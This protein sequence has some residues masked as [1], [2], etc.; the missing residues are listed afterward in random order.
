MGDKDVY[1]AIT[2]SHTL[3]TGALMPLELG[4]DITIDSGFLFGVFFFFKLFKQEF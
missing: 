1:T 2:W 4:S 3:F